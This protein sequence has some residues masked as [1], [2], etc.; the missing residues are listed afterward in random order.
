MSQFEQTP[1]F[2]AW[3][4]LAYAAA[5]SLLIISIIT[6][7]GIP[8]GR[9]YLDVRTFRLA[10]ISTAA[11]GAIT[12]SMACLVTLFLR[13]RIRRPFRFSLRTLF[14]VTTLVAVTLEF[15]VC[16]VRG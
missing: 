6:L 4:L 7:F 8:P 10:L 13:T 16:I 2:H 11:G 1:Q 12:S 15:I 5:Y 14:I 3:K 9:Q